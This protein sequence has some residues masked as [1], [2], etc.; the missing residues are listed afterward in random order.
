[1]ISIPGPAQFQ[2]LALVILQMAGIA[3]LAI[4]CIYGA[5]YRH[6]APRRRPPSSPSPPKRKRKQCNSSNIQRRLKVLDGQSVA[7]N[8][9]ILKIE[10]LLSAAVV[11]RQ[12]WDAV[13]RQVREKGRQPSSRTLFNFK[14]RSAD[15]LRLAT[16]LEHLKTERHGLHLSY[17]SITSEL[18]RT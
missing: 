18:H 7:L 13:I 3:S 12:R 9:E 2:R 11:Q 16:T 8:D 10:R 6:R 17:R 4:A 5:T 1:M 14:Q 15:I